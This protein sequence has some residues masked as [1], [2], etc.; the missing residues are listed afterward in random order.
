MDFTDILN[1]GIRRH[2]DRN[3]KKR[4]FGKCDDCEI[5]ALL[6]TYEDEDEGGMVWHVCETCYTRMLDNKD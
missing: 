4:K 6:I 5:P 3:M 2:I 1:K